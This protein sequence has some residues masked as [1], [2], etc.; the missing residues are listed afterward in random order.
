MGAK[1][2]GSGQTCVAANR[3]FVQQKVSSSIRF[4]PMF[5]SRFLKIH[6]AFVTKMTAAMKNLVVGD[7]MKPKTTIGPLINEGA[8][9]K[10]GVSLVRI[11]RQS[12]CGLLL[13]RLPPFSETRNRKVPRS[14]LVGNVLK[15]HVSSQHF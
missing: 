3:F 13:F 6:D 1:F 10:V 5:I 4:S 8:V 11:L 15:V 14:Y 7:G 9:E 12:S 2:R